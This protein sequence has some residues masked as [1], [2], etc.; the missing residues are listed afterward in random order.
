[1]TSQRWKETVCCGFRFFNAP[2]RSFFVSLLLQ[3][4]ECVQ[5]LKQTI[6][7]QNV[8]VSLCFSLEI[9]AVPAEAQACFSLEIPAVPAEAQACFSLEMPAVPAEAQ[10]CFSLEIPA[11]PAEAQAC[12]SVEMPASPAEAEA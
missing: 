12:F 1:M 3:V 7:V 8:P 4:E 5:V 9:P 11:V 2:P 6:S 10:A